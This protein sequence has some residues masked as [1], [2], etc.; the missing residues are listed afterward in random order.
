MQSDK[1]TAKGTLV[2]LLLNREDP[3]YNVVFSK[4]ALEQYLFVTAFHYWIAK[5]PG[6]IMP[7]NRKEI[8]ELFFSRNSGNSYKTSNV[9]VMNCKFMEE[10]ARNTNKKLKKYSKN[11]ERYSQVVGKIH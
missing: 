8:I 9:S 11:K 5:K 2:T 6:V 4:A 10:R 7:P 1:K 3:I